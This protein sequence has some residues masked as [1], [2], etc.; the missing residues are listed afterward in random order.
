MTSA[1]PI[2]CPDLTISPPAIQQSSSSAPSR[3]PGRATPSL[4]GDRSLWPNTD[5]AENVAMMTSRE[6]TARKKTKA[7]PPRWESTSESR[8]MAQENDF[9]PGTHAPHDAFTSAPVEHKLRALA[10]KG[11][12]GPGTRE[13]TPL[14]PARLRCHPR[15]PCIRCQRVCMMRGLQ[16]LK[17]GE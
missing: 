5:P 1:V 7:D 4:P 14:I 10:G 9:R 17:P 16:E 6:A 3:T 13:Y 15:R 11:R 8:G 12:H 2:P